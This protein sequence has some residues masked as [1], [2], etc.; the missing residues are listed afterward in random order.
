MYDE[1]FVLQIATGINHGFR[2]CFPM[3]P[4][5]YF[6]TAFS[7]NIARRLLLLIVL[8]KAYENLSFLISNKSLISN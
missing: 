7:Q 8:L 6:K 4:K 2:K 3:N 5:K 1:V